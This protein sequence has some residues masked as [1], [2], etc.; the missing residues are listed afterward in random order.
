MARNEL[1][2]WWSG[3]QVVMRSKCNVSKLWPMRQ[4]VAWPSLIN[5]KKSN[6]LLRSV[7]LPS[8]WAPTDILEDGHQL[9]LKQ[10]S[11]YKGMMKIKINWKNGSP[12]KSSNKGFFENCPDVDS[13]RTRKNIQTEHKWTYDPLAIHTNM[14]WKILSVDLSLSREQAEL[15]GVNSVFWSTLA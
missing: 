7:F 9:Q 6:I 11:Q 13:E 4:F 12:N 2:L 8:L 1:S 10:R 14:A 5:P 15:P 3:T